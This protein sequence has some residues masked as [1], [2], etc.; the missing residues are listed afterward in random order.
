MPSITIQGYKFEVPDAVLA[1]YDHFLVPDAPEG[2]RSTVRQ[3]LSEN[4]RNNFAGSVRKALNG[5]ESIPDE[6]LNGLQAEFAAYAEKYEFG[7]RTAGEA[8]QK[9]D[10]VTKEMFKLAKE[11]I[12]KAYFAKYG[13]KIEKD[14]LLE[15]TDQLVDK[16]RE[17]YM[18]RA[19]AILRQREQVATDTLESLGL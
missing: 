4:L 2:L 11:D 18:K 3:T 8:R 15:R 12:T 5:A 14:L 17:S 7:V 16:E 10:P 19:K 6:Q 1:K 13:T 9:L